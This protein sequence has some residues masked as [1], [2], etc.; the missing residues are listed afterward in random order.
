MRALKQEPPEVQFD[1]AIE[2]D[3]KIKRVSFSEENQKLKVVG[4]YPF[5]NDDRYLELHEH[6][7]LKLNKRDRK[8]IPTTEDFRRFNSI[9]N[10][11][12]K[13]LKKLNGH[14]LNGEYHAAMKFGSVIRFYPECYVN[15]RGEKSLMFGY[16]YDVKGKAL[17]RYYLK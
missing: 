5:K 13:A 12:N 9:F 7:P 3:G 2:Q 15:M 6:G 17:V 10:E 11:L 4:I 1:L 14:T 16:S 8:F